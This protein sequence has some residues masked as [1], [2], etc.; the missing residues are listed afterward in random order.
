M[1]LH[2]EAAATQPILL[3]QRWGLSFHMASLPSLCVIGCLQQRISLGMQLNSGFVDVRGP[4]AG[5][6]PSS[7]LRVVLL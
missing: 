5:D 3:G 1:N 6:L 4:S 7:G 2:R